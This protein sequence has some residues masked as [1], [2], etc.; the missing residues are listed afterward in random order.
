MEP[1]RVSFTW[2]GV[3]TLKLASPRARGRCLPS[4]CCR[5][6]AACTLRMRFTGSKRPSSMRTHIMHMTKA[7]NS[8]HTPAGESRRTWRVYRPRQ[9]AREGG[10]SAAARVARIRAYHVFDQHAEGHAGTRSLHRAVLFLPHRDSRVFVVSRKSWVRKVLV[11]FLEC[12]GG[13]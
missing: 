4:C 2:K 8:P 10:G 5:A 11:N 13:V 3:P 12:P 7:Q 6:A 9:L 1:W